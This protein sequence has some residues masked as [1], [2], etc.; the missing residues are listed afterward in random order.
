M[1]I[2]IGIQQS[3]I[4]KLLTVLHCG[5]ISA[6]IAFWLPLAVG[7]YLALDVQD[8]KGNVG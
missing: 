6:A 2:Q 1:N 8:V 5:V 7:P 4:G 3:T